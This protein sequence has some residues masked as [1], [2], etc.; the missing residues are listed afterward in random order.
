MYCNFNCIIIL[1]TFPILKYFNCIIILTFS[2]AMRSKLTIIDSNILPTYSW[3]Y[4]YIKCFSSLPINEIL[5]TTEGKDI[6]AGFLKPNSQ[7]G[8]KRHPVT[9][10]R[11][12]PSVLLCCLLQVALAGSFTVRFYVFIFTSLWGHRAEVCSSSEAALLLHLVAYSPWN[13]MVEG[14]F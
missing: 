4:L 13:G 1:D 12:V 6:L 10:L 8:G 14:S 9:S 2:I 11:L 5:S 7:H 3:L